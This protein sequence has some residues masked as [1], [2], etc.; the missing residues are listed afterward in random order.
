MDTFELIIEKTIKAIIEMALRD[1]TPE[2]IERNRRL[3]KAGVIE[4]DQYEEV[5]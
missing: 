5:L 4:F 2:A 1:N 3:M